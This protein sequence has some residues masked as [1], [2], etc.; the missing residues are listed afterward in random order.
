LLDRSRIKR[1]DRGI[2][3]VM[4][5]TMGISTIIGSEDEGHIAHTGVLLGV[6]VR[7]FEAEELPEGT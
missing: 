4:A 2:A 6:E 1:C 5:V 7:E 3:R